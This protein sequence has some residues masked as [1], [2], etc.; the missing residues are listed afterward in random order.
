MSNLHIVGAASAPHS[1]LP[2]QIRV[3]I[4]SDSRIQTGPRPV[5]VEVRD[6][7]VIL[8]GW[9]PRLPDKVRA[10]VVARDLAGG[11]PF[12]SDLLVGP[13]DRQPD[14]EIVARVEDSFEEDRWIDSTAL[15]VE[16]RDGVV[17][18]GGTIDS[19]LH[20]RF[21]RAL[22]WWVPGVRGVRDDLRILHPDPDPLNDE[23]L[24]EAVILMLDKDP[25]VD[26]TEILVLVKD[27]RVDLSGTVAG[28]DARDAA[29]NDA[30]IVTDVRDVVNQIEVAVVAGA[31]T[32][33]GLGS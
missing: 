32:I 21:V 28:E 13:P 22:P 26:R 10:E 17:F 16:A 9:V 20:W 19:T 3:A 2:E 8:S 27:G 1:S 31:P 33:E 23:L 15:R 4:A 6:G 5:G 29:G 12:E 7:R 14:A 25:L 30:W 18:L 24:A 11:L